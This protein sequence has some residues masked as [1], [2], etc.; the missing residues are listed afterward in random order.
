M[1]RNPPDLFLLLVTLTLLALGLIIVFSASAPESLRLTKGANV[2]HYGLRQLLFAAVGVFLMLIAAKF[3]YNN[4]RRLSPWVLVSSIAFLVIVLFVS[5]DIKGSHRW[6]NLGF[7][8]FQP[9]EYA[10]LGT[11]LILA[12]YITEIKKGIGNLMVGVIIPCIF[13][14]FICLLILLEPDLGTAVVIFA[15]FMIMIFAAGARMSHL[16]FLT[17]FGVAAVTVLVI[18]EPYRFK[19]LIAFLDPWKDPRGDG[20]QIIQSLYALGSGGPLGMGLGM[21]R[22]KFNYL[23]ESHTDY[24]FSILGEELGLLGTITVILLFF[25]LAWRGYKIAISARDVYGK[26]LATG[27]TS[28]LIFQA[29]LNIGVVTSSI[30]VTG[31]TLP[32]LSYGGSSLMICLLSVGILLNISKNCE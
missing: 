16:S 13:V 14:G 10:K 23:P 8:N 30:P 21:S 24:I 18:I 9:S 15:T 31:I 29:L 20:W 17:F 11:I 22:Q 6:I 19:R 5:E 32:F 4:W 12:H 3:P 26:V 25:M 2:F 28:Y 7:F 27:L 1:K